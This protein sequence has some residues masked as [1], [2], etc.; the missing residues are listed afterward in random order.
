MRK[1]FLAT[2]SKQRQKLL[3][4][5]GI[6]F[7]VCPSRIKEKRL[8]KTSFSQLVEENALAKA[9]AVAKKINSGVI[10]AADT[11]VVSNS[12]KIYGKPKNLKEAKSMLKKLAKDPQ[13]VYTGISV[14]D[15]DNKKSY[16]DFE[17]TKVFM[18]KLTDKE[19]DKYFSCVSPLDKAGAFDIQNKGSLFIRRIEGCFYNVVGLPLYKL[20]K[21]LKKV[22]IDVF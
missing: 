6:R 15:A 13:W 14:V 22:S 5:L 19:I 3:K 11:I 20:S 10:I 17:K 9:Q 12:G 2:E 7:K 18:N 21:L 8:V 16:A 4:H 1:I